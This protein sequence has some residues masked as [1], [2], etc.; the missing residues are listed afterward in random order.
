MQRSSN[1][2]HDHEPGAP[3]R[4]KLDSGL[5]LRAT[6]D[7][8]DDGGATMTAELPW[9]RVGTP[10]TVELERALRPGRIEWVSLRA[11]AG[12]PAK[13]VVRVAFDA[14][15]TSIVDTLWRAS[16]VVATLALV[17]IGLHAL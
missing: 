14:G 12:E 17:F 8:W 9:L 10:A 13:L 4:V 6:T 5:V 3:V 7:T 11:T 1:E 16:A 2:P 15:R